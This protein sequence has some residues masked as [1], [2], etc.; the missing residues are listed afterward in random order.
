MLKIS[1]I[2]DIVTFTKTHQFR[3]RYIDN[4][5]KM[6]SLFGNNEI[7]INTIVLFFFFLRFKT[8]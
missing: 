7:N 2:V 6:Y 4:P 8:L 1:I 3:T 5:L